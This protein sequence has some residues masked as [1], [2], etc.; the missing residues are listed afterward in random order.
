MQRSYPGVKRQPHPLLNHDVMEKL[1]HKCLDF[2]DNDGLK[3]E[4]L[5]ELLTIS[6]KNKNLIRRSKLFEQL[7][8]ALDKAAFA[9]IME[10]RTF[11]LEKRKTD[12]EYKK[13]ANDISPEEKARLIWE[14]E[15]IE[16]SLNDYKNMQ[17]DQ[18]DIQE[19]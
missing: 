12:N 2:Q 18:I 15:K 17:L 10:A 16:S 7:E 4:Q 5:R 8:S 1:K 13:E 11:A 9:N 19:I 6:D 14:I 3:F